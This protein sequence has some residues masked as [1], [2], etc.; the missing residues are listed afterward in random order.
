MQLIADYTFFAFLK[1]FSAEKDY[2]ELAVL[3]EIQQEL[4]SQGNLV[5]SHKVWTDT[6]HQSHGVCL[7]FAEI[8]I[9]EEY[10]RNLQFEEQYISSVVEG[11]DDTRI[12]CPV[13]GVSVGLSIL[14]FSKQYN[15]CMIFFV[16]SLIGLLLCL[17]C[18]LQKK[19]EHQQPFYQLSLR[20]LPEH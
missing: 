8:S 13:C 10:E 1:M 12:I 16:N 18:V 19:C 11:L 9:I 15:M 17:S 6:S 20:T 4:M 14:T 2:D 7:R 3:E 5:L